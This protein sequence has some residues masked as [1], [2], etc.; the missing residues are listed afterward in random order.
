MGT[1]QVVIEQLSLIKFKR[2]SSITL[3]TF[4][5]YAIIMTNTVIV[6]K[7]VYRECGVFVSVAF[8]WV[9]STS[10]SGEIHVVFKHF[11]NFEKITFKILKEKLHI[12]CL[13]NFQ[14]STVQTATIKFWSKSYVQI[15][16][17]PS[18][19]LLVFPQKTGKSCLQCH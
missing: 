2:W 8:F 14:N 18:N 17:T 19:S 7:K 10:L 1:G 3:K 11:Q 12:F 6:T 15:L 9:H 16:C 13:V 4:N 5:N